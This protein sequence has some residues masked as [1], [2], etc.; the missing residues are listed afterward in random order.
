MQI[1]ISKFLSTLQHFCLS[2][3][4]II[5]PEEPKPHQLALRKNSNT[6]TRTTTTNTSQLLLW[7]PLL[8]SILCLTS[9]FSKVL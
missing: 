7:P 9:Q 5:W 4:R 8:L 6:T 3:E 2:N 1:N